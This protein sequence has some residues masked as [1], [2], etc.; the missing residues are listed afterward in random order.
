MKAIAWA[1][2]KWLQDAPPGVSFH[3]EI[4]LLRSLVDQSETSDCQVVPVGDLDFDAR[5]YADLV[6][7]RNS[8]QARLMFGLTQKGPQDPVRIDVLTRP[9]PGHAVL[10]E[11][12]G[13]WQL[14]LG[15]SFLYDKSV[16]ELGLPGLL[17]VLLDSRS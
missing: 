5:E 12:D 11:R 14:I 13:T 16:E 6:L 15:S 3:E 2:P 9:R 8:D 10:R 7:E 17:H 1:E 4:K